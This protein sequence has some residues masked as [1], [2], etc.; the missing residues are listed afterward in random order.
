MIGLPAMGVLAHTTGLPP[1]VWRVLAKAHDR[2]NWPSTKAIW[3]A[4][5]S[6]WPT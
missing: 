6:C 2:R 4:T 5:T 3:S 1:E